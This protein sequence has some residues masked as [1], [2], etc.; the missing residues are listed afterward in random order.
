MIFTNTYVEDFFFSI[1]ASTHPSHPGSYLL[2]R[3][4]DKCPRPLEKEWP[5]M[6]AQIGP[7]SQGQSRH[8]STTPQI[9][10]GRTTF[11]T[12]SAQGTCRAPSKDSGGCACGGMG[13]YVH[14]LYFL[15]N[16]AVKLR[17]SKEIKVINFLK[18]Q[19]WSISIGLACQVAPWCA[20]CT[21]AQPSSSAG[22]LLSSSHGSLKFGP[23]LS[24]T[25]DSP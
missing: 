10:M 13:V 4:P 9:L 8:H 21:R 3:A 23:L 11:T 14:S 7:G 2:F 15:F 5:H 22:Q 12:P 19:W 6:E 20:Q 17:C 1:S 18:R 25:T 24:D 16:F